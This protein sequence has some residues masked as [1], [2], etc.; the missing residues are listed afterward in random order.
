LL[1]D[2]IEA[3]DPGFGIERMRAFATIAEPLTP[4]QANSPLTIEPQ[5]DV[6]S[7]V[8]TLANQI[9]GDHLFRFAA[10]ESDVPE[11]SV[12]RIPPTATETGQVWPAHG[13]PHIPTP[14]S[15]RS[16]FGVEK[17]CDDNPFCES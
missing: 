13:H 10:I 4:R 14:W 16:H 2:K 11:R 5:V 12:K 17:G 15:P 3:V 9:G 1:C 8:D 7:L 6:T